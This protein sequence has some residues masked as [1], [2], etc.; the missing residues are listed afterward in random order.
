MLDINSIRSKFP[1][2]KN[3]PGL[4]YLDSAATALKPQSVIEAE[5]KYYEEYSAN[6]ERGLYPL[7]EKATA[8]YD[9]VR[10]KTARFVGAGRSEEII[11][12]RGTTESLNLLS[13]SLE[14]L[15]SEGDEILVTEMEHHSNFLPWQALAER[16]GATL[17]V[18]PLSCISCSPFQGELPDV[19]VGVRGNDI[20]SDSNANYPLPTSP[21]PRGRGNADSFMLDPEKLKAF[22]TPR[23]KI[24][25]FVYVSNVLGTINPVADIVGEAKQLNPNIITVVDAA[26]AAPHFQIDVKSLGCDFLTFSSHK[27]FGPTGV[28]VLWG[29]YKLLETLR[30]FHYGGEMVLEA[31]ADKSVF[32]EPPHRF[33]A[34]TPNI[35]G[36]IAF[37]A[38]VDFIESLDWDTVRK[39]EKELLEY[40]IAQLK[41]TFGKSIRI[42]GPENIEDRSGVVAFTFEGIHPHD[43]AQV[44][45]ESDIC[46]RAGQHCAQPLHNTLGIP[47][48]A[49][50]SVSI[51]NSKEDIDT[52]VETLKSTK[53]LF[54]K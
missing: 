25:A 18:L 34:G 49:R 51:Y 22:I 29:K 35:A 4:V 27:M 50:I 46:I 6:V 21:L 2:F 28:G 39:H 54:T 40:V 10:E 30:P 32:K 5:R 9:A 13:Y 44:L 3:R 47:A 26:Q 52:L 11:F 24:F 20:E 36:V 45:S 15:I 17:K 33:E 41:K 1:I 42:V 48:T 12:T 31:H 37:G 53:G 8:E 14:P 43:I 23:T 38:A 7:S 19:L 16:T